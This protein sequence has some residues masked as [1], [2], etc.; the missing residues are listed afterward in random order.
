MSLHI[1]KYIY[2]YIYVYIYIYIYFSPSSKVGKVTNESENVAMFRGNRF[3][4]KFINKN[5]INFSSEISLQRRFSLLLK[6]YKF[7]PT[8]NKTDQAK[9]KRELEEYGRKLRLIWHFR[10]DEKTL[11]QEKLKPKSTFNARNKAAVIETY[12][13][14]LEERLL[15]TEIPFKRFSN[16]TQ[17]K[18]NAM[19]SLK[20][21]QSII[22]KSA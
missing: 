10:Y 21:D 22:I 4:G 11:S 8:A 13:S 14:C 19:I 15:D 3:E 20:D 6:G 5:V 9:L 12:L 17:D 7:V 16:L 2:I 18:R 1:Y